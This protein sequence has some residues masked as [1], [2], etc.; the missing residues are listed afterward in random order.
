MNRERAIKELLQ[1]AGGRGLTCHEIAEKLHI[2]PAKVGQSLKRLR[3]HLRH[4]NSE[5]DGQKVILWRA[6]DYVTH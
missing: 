4:M 5:R 3:E 6:P 1:A 2:E